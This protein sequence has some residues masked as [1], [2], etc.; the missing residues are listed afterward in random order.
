VEGHVK[1]G[2]APG[3]V[4][5]PG[6]KVTVCGCCATHTVCCCCCGTCCCCCCCSCCCTSATQAAIFEVLAVVTSL[7]CAI[8]TSACPITAGNPSAPERATR[9]HSVLLGMTPAPTFPIGNHSTGGIAGVCNRRATV[10]SKMLRAMSQRAP[11]TNARKNQGGAG[12]SACG[13]S[14]LRPGGTR[15]WKRSWG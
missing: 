7:C 14:N 10:R 1:A 8:A 3:G 15:R 13:G 6:F 9:V 2:T 12:V 4:D 11:P 5:C